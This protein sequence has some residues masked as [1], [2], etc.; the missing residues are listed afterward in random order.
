MRKYENYSSALLA[1]ERADGQDLTN[2]F[3]Q[4][5]VIDKFSMQFELGWKLLK[6]LL[7]YEGESIAATGSPRDIIKAAFATFAFVDCG[8]D[9]R[10]RHDG[11]RHRRRLDG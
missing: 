6:K 10:L 4:S 8:H 9:Q 1:L 11:R 2:E 3:I 5:G 7:A